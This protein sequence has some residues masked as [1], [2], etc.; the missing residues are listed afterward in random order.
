MRHSHILLDIMGLE[1]K[2]YSRTADFKGLSAVTI[3]PDHPSN[4]TCRRWDSFR[5]PR[6][7][8]YAGIEIMSENTFV[9]QRVTFSASSEKE[10]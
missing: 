6:L 3:M 9:K 2:I 4:K 10:R 5:Y 1:A 8:Q 7:L